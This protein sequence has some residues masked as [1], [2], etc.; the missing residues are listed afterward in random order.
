ME[1]V[2]EPDARSPA[3]AMAYLTK[4]RQILRY[5]G[6]SDANME[7]G[8]FRCE[9]NLSLRSKG[10]TEL[11]SKVEL[12]N[13]NS[14]RAASRGMEFEVK[15][16]AAI[17][18][19]GGKVPSETRGWR[20]ET[21]ETASQRSKELAHDYRYFPEPDL[22]PLAVSREQVEEL[23]RR[24]P[25]LPE[26]RRR[27]FVGAYG[28]SAHEAELICDSRTKADYYEAAV[29]ATASAAG[30]AKLTANW[31]LGDLSRLVNAA[32]IEVADSKVRPEQLAALVT[33]VD[34]G[35]V[36]G[37]SAKEVLDVMFETGG[38]PATI[39]AE[40]GLGTMRDEDAV[41]AA[42]KA[43]ADVERKGH[44]RIQGRQECRDQRARRRR[45]EGDTRPRQ[46]PARA[47]AARTRANDLDRRMMAVLRW[48]A[49][50][51]SI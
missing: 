41:I 30:L 15:R 10:S 46:R 50:G 47:R 39:V 9:P 17:L 20:D 5:L 21:G 4:L 35:K 6:V 8:N 12:K 23:R 19:A 34:E 48:P 44:R 43:A 7:E 27:R 40:R 14:F 38:D 16:Q 24:L 32:G 42:V 18:L 11:G 26:A 1:I 37:T 45:H 51:Q 36:S 49:G 25:E 3:E 2:T 31:V 29:K 22:P 13:L 28:L 33:L